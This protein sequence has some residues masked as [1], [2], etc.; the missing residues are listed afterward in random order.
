MRSMNRSSGGDGVSPRYSMAIAA[1]GSGAAR[2]SAIRS[3]PFA[4]E[5]APVRAPADP[6]RPFTGAPW[7]FTDESERVGPCPPKLNSRTP[8][9]PAVRKAIM[10]FQ[11]AGIHTIPICTDED[12]F[13]RAAA[14]DDL[15]LCIQSHGFRGGTLTA[16]MSGVTVDLRDAAL[17]PEGATIRVQSALSGI[18]I[19]VPR[20]WEV[21]CEVGMVWGEIEG[22]RFA[23]PPANERRPRLRVTGMVV[24]GGLCVK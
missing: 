20:D 22:E 16:V 9:F 21:V 3:G 24:G 10:E 11:A 14:L 4:R 7:A 17:S 6:P 19:L 8:H 12:S 2:V 18:H 23:E 13:E 15:I 5:I 1:Y